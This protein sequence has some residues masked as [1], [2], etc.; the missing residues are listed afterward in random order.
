MCR[1]L[2]GRTASSGRKTTVR[3]IECN[4][5]GPTRQCTFEERLRV[6]SMESR[7][8]ECGCTSDVC[9]ASRT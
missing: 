2:N 4:S 8:L 3:V 7:D 9:V 5:L 1:G 6:D